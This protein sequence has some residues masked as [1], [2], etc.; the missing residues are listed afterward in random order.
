MLEKTL[1]VYRELQQCLDKFAVC[2]QLLNQAWKSA[3]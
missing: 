3:Y 1:D 2:F